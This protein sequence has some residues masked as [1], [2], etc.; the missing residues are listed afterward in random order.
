M[1]ERSVSVIVCTYTEERWWLLSRAVESLQRQ[2]LPPL[3]IIVVVDHAPALLERVRTELSAVVALPN[4][5]Q[6]GLSGAR[7]SGIAGS[8][9]DLIGFF[10]D[11]ATARRDWVQ[12][13]AEWFD[14]GCVFA[15]GGA[16]IPRWETGRPRWFPEEF[17]WVVGCSYRGLPSVATRVRNVFG[18]DSM[19]RREV[20]ETVGLFRAE[21][22]RI[23]GNH[24]GCEE[25]ELCIRIR[26]QWPDSVLV[27]EPAA[28]VE[29]FVPGSRA[30]WRYFRSRCYWEGVSKAV[31]SDL[32]GADD[33]LTSERSYVRRTV[34]RGIARGM[35]DAARLGDAWGFRRAGAVIVGTLL[36]T[37]GY[38]RGRWG[39]ESASRA[40]RRRGWRRD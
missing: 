8:G 28:V 26:Q 1:V 36:T 18:G 4:I 27:Y 17:D 30:A 11:D 10:D 34:P 35:E 22:G 32:R 16:S 23:A 7:N 19:F 5:Q 33:A 25:T 24:L 14:D 39:F 3:E 2:S 40:T 38:C 20:F 37:A 13:L 9:G 21:L 12:R 31:V 15:A 29:H 6:R